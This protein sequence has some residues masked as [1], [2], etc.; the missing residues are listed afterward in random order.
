MDIILKH[1]YTIIVIGTSSKTL[2]LVSSLAKPSKLNHTLNTYLIGM[3]FLLTLCTL[4][5]K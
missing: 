3:F 4:Y 2:T 1:Q 5:T